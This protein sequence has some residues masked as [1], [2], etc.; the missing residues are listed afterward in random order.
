[1]TIVEKTL[2]L[3]ASHCIRSQFVDKALLYSKCGHQL[4]P[5]RIEL[6]ELYGLALLY[7]NDLKKLSDLLS[8]SSTKSR[9]IDYLHAR[10][11]ILQ[12][13]ADSGERVRSYLAHGRNT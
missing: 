7:K 3:L 10:L 9:N 6:F 8:G 5:E 12:G 11:A 13:Q 1:M 2:V 4:F